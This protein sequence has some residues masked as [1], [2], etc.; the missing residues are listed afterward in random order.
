M[1]SSRENSP[2]RHIPREKE[3]GKHRRR[4]RRPQDSKRQPREELTENPTN[5]FHSEGSEDVDPNYG[6]SRRPSQARKSRPRTRTRLQRSPVSSSFQE[7]VDITSRIHHQRPTFGS[8]KSSNEDD[9]DDYLS[10]PPG[11]NWAKGLWKH[12]AKAAAPWGDD[13]PEHTVLSL[14]PTLIMNPRGRR[15]MSEPFYYERG[16]TDRQFAET[17][18]YQYASLRLRDVGLAQKLVAYR[19]I[20]YV[21]VLQ[22]RFSR[23]RRKWMVAKVLPITNSSDKEARDAFMILLRYPPSHTY[24]LTGTVDE[25]IEPGVML[26]FEIIETLDTSKI[27]P[28]IFISAFLSLGVALAYGFAMDGDFSTGFSIGSWFITAAGFIG[29][30]ISISEYGGPE[31]PTTSQMGVGMDDAEIVPN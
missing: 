7:G 4:R 18:K 16:W 8:N 25:L 10:E 17:L 22:V 11:L 15:Y 13:S 28:A 31:T 14:E 6:A 9:E 29:A 3:C 12:A 26:H 20:R 1:S 21:N 19:Q 5:D 23:R 27:N 30:L 24:H 2:D